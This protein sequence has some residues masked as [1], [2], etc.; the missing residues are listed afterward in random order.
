M[1]SF[2]AK[3]SLLPLSPQAQTHTPRQEDCAFEERL[4]SPW[5]WANSALVLPF[6]HPDNAVVLKLP[7]SALSR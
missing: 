5:N 1:A 3:G 4:L 6:S 7:R 2:S